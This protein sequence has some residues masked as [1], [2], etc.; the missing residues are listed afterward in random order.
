MS[1]LTS[2]HCGAQV[3]PLSVETDAINQPILDQA[4]IALRLRFSPRSPPLKLS[5]AR[6]LHET[7]V[8]L[9]SRPSHTADPLQ[10]APIACVP[11]SEFIERAIL[12]L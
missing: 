11:P 3:A 6:V 8:P 9:E 10:S 2:Q 7:A 5:P 4:D 12:S 1:N